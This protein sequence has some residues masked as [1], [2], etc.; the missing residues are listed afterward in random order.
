M[1]YNDI[2]DYSVN[3]KARN[4]VFRFETGRVLS[5]QKPS[6]YMSSNGFWILNTHPVSKR[7]TEF[8]ALQLHYNP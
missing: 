3:C 2:N 6:G 5:I 1:Q 8:R 4:F 7:N